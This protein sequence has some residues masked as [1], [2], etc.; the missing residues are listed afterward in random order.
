MDP[1]IL[2]QLAA[3]AN[4]IALLAADDPTIQELVNK[5]IEVIEAMLDEYINKC[6]DALDGLRSAQA[7]T[8]LAEQE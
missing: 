5:S 8:R 6:I 7:A 4:M 3:Q 2:L 1:V